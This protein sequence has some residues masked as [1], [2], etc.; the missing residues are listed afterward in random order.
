M[1]KLIFVDII[2]NIAKEYGLT[3]FF[4]YENDKE[5]SFCLTYT[6]K[7]NYKLVIDKSFHKDKYKTEDEFKTEFLDSYSE[8]IQQIK[9]Q[10]K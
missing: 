4:F 9:R 8:T 7:M 5:C 3:L 1:S 6:D 10:K 2:Y